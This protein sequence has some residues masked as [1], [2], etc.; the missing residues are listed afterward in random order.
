[1]NARNLILFRAVLAVIWHPFQRKVIAMDLAEYLLRA[2]D[3]RS[4]D[5]RRLFVTTSTPDEDGL[6][7]RG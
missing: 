3:D 4:A 2:V 5:D 7:V 1:M 6:W